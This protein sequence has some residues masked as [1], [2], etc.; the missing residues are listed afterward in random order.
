MDLYGKLQ[1]A[2]VQTTL[3]PALQRADNESLPFQA[4]LNRNVWQSCDWMTDISFTLPQKCRAIISY[5]AFLSDNEYN[6]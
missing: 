4:G 3:N 5:S 1:Y 6:E 2:H